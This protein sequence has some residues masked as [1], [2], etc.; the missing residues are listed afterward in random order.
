M[1]P[2]SLPS[3]ADSTFTRPS[4]SSCIGPF[5]QRAPGVSYVPL[6]REPHG[7]YCG[8]SH[9]LFE[10]P[11][12]KLDRAAIEAVVLIETPNA[13]FTGVAGQLHYVWEDNVNNALDKT[14]LEGDF[15]G[16]SIADFQIELTGLK[17]PLV[18]DFVL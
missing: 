3:V 5:S 10:V 1:R 13:A 8:R 14:I 7:L 11:N 6:G 17:T 15:N 9:P 18:G 16:D 2:M 12:Q 4:E